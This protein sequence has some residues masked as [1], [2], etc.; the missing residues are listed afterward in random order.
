MN[1]GQIENS[2]A[3][4][5]RRVRPDRQP[6]GPCEAA[7]QQQTGELVEVAMDGPVRDGPQTET[8]ARQVR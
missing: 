6:T 3:A 2:W 1:W 8:V 7:S 4:M 5:T